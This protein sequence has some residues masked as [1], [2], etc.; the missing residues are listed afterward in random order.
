M[1]LDKNKHKKP[2]QINYFYFGFLFLVLAMV[3]CYHVL[4]IGEGSSYSVCFFLFYAL[5]QCFLEVGVLILLG[6]LIRQYLPKTLSFLFIQA[7]FFLFII[8]LLDFPLVRLLDWSIWYTLSFVM[9]ESLQNF[10]EMLQASNVSM[11]T[12]FLGGFF[13]LILL[14]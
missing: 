9:Q 6:H 7:T 4:L 5:I 10:I 12:W 13:G 8:H 1:S 2:L 11:M 14:A 3:H